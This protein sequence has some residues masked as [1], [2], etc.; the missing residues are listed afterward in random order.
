[1]AFQT[2]QR[3]RTSPNQR[4]RDAA[5]LIV[6]DRRAAAPKVLMGR[7]HDGH[8]FMPGKFVFPGGRLERSDRFMRAASELSPETEVRLAARVVRPSSSRG[9]ALALTAIRETYEETGLVIGR[10]APAQPASSRPIPAGWAPFLGAGALP[11]LGSIAFIGRA[12]TPPRRP[13]R[14]DTR[15]FSVDREEIVATADGFVGPDK[16]LVELVWVD[17]REAQQLDLPRITSIMLQELEGRLEAGF[18]H[19]A[20]IPFYRERHGRFLRDLL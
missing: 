19:D 2:A 9:R 3:E 20:P 1:M 16:E 6:V 18:P 12:I 14:F 5:T 13:K 11:H 7:R 8:K 15:F 10:S 4:P 17:L